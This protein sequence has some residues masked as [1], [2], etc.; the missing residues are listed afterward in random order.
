M[1]DGRPALVSSSMAYCQDKRMNPQALDYRPQIIS[2]T[3][4][5]QHQYSGFAP[6]WPVSNFQQLPAGVYH[7]N[8]NQAHTPSPMRKEYI[9]T[10]E[11]RTAALEEDLRKA[12]EERQAART[13]ND[14]LLRRLSQSANTKDSGKA[15][16]QISH[17]QSKV[18]VLKNENHRLKS[19][20][21][22]F[23][24]NRALASQIQAFMP[25]KR[26]D[27]PKSSSFEDSG[28]LIY[29]SPEASPVS[30]WATLSP[31]KK[32]DVFST[33]SSDFPGIE[34]LHCSSY[35][36]TS[37]GHHDLVSGNENILLSRNIQKA[38]KA[39]RRVPEEL[40]GLFDDVP[41]VT[42]ESSPL[43][44]LDPAN[45]ELN[46]QRAAAASNSRTYIHHFSEDLRE[47]K[48][49]TTELVGL[50]SNSREIGERLRSIQL[51]QTPKR[52]PP[53]SRHPS[54]RPAVVQAGL[55][56]SLWSPESPSKRTPLRHPFEEFRGSFSS[57]PLTAHGQVGI[58]TRNDGS[59]M[60]QSKSRHSQPDAIHSLS[61]K[62]SASNIEP[63]N[64]RQGFRSPSGRLPLKHFP[65]ETSPLSTFKADPDSP[66][67]LS[68][69][70]LEKPRRLQ[71]RWVD[72]P[73]VDMV[74][75]V[76]CSGVR[77][78][79]F[80]HHP[81][82]FRT[83]M[84]Q[85]IPPGVALH[86]VLEKVRGGLVVSARLLSTEVI[87]GTQTAMVT[88]LRE[89]AALDYIDFAT[90]NSITFAGSQAQISFAETATWPSTQC[91]R[92]G[93]EQHGHSRCLRI[94][95]LPSKAPVAMLKKKLHPVEYYG[96]HVIDHRED[97]LSG[98]LEVRFSSVATSVLARAILKL[99]PAYCRSRIN[100]SPDP[101]ALPCGTLIEGSG[102]ELKGRA[103]GVGCSDE[104]RTTG[105]GNSDGE[106]KIEEEE[107]T[108]QR[109]IDREGH[110]DHK[111]DTR[112]DKQI[113]RRR[114]L[115]SE[116]GNPA[117]QPGQKSS[118]ENKGGSAIPVLANEKKTRD[119]PGNGVWQRQATVES[120]W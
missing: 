120:T 12:R 43:M 93:I 29:V 119:G 14:Y 69:E 89:S 85:K 23:Q 65:Q 47:P 49:E 36:L 10:L 4:Y 6:Q 13:V 61:E 112:G 79:P 40:R 60:G 55:D 28:D 30:L 21:Q 39:A 34:A 72:C 84:M 80:A 68:D 105:N 11:S 3:S 75:D 32:S 103:D 42:W 104:G 2:N 70:F 8:W 101:C 110:P 86:D 33:D 17:L 7:P 48:T 46:D 63:D 83:V 66:D 22:K 45:T 58:P 117:S 5:P 44:E 108:G 76:P 77:Y 67:S 9:T 87:C 102:C 97:G 111:G 109:Q 115:S 59:P 107:P 15:I 37:D 26:F 98:D 90:T 57:N 116:I 52:S 118:T 106:R 74:E 95:D 114:Q 24:T 81:D 99:T 50:E 19:K 53:R 56:I 96:V 88:F 82:V 25:L 51:P 38:R 18:A 62:P 94:Y 20:L 113:I 35:S 100:F 41:V 27:T 73:D 31:M 64:S 78:L 54:E 92:D 1:A 71:F 91:I 16:R